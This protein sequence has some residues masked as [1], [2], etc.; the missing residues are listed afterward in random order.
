MATWTI[1]SGTGSGTSL[2][3][4][5]IVVTQTGP[6]PT[7]ITTYKFLPPKGDGDT[8]YGTTTSSPP[9]FTGMT[10]G[11]QTWT[12]RGGSTPPFPPPKDSTWSGSCDDGVSLLGADPGTWAAESGGGTFGGK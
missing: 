6:P 10:I 4:Y 9:S 7:Q 5:R 3:N 1:K 11:T 2:V 12:V 8:P